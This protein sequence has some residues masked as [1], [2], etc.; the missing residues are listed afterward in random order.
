[1]QDKYYSTPLH[2]VEC[3]LADATCTGD[4][5]ELCELAV[6]L[7]FEAVSLD[8]NQ[9]PIWTL[10]DQ[11][12]RYFSELNLYPHTC[13]PDVSNPSLSNA[14]NTSQEVKQTTPALPSYI[15]S[16]NCEG[17]GR[18]LIQQ[19]KI[20]IDWDE[21]TS[22]SH[23]FQTLALALWLE[24]QH[25]PCI[26]ANA[27]KRADKTFA[28]VANSGTG[29]S[30]L[31]AKLQQTGCDW[32]TD[33]M[34]ALH[35]IGASTLS[36][37]APKVYPSWPI[38]RMWPDSVENALGGEV[39]V[40]RKVHNRFDKRLIEMPELTEESKHSSELSTIYILN[41]TVTDNH[42]NKPHCRIET[43]NSSQALILLLQNSILGNAYSALELEAD[44]IRQLSILVQTTKVKMITYSSGKENLD[45]VSKAIL[46]D[47]DTLQPHSTS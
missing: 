14:D 5:T 20:T 40:L 34:I 33:D 12:L 39:A 31:S 16:V 47:L 29:K 43:I 46:E 22:S 19:H 32:L 30:T 27:L 23:Y 44:R 45:F 15:L 6:E 25:V 2:G 4:K 17:K 24:T 18:F 3:F 1:M 8:A 10:K 21:G 11:G 26:H 13:P 35:Q 7:A 37:N 28:L 9:Q 41:R 36:G 38:A 42:D